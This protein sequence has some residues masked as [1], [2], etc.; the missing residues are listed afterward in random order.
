MGGGRN[1][2]SRPQIGPIERQGMSTIG[3]TFNGFRHARSDSNR[4]DTTRLALWVRTDYNAPA[5]KMAFAGDEASMAGHP[6]V[7]HMKL[8]LMLA[9]MFIVAAPTI[10]QAQQLEAIDKPTLQEAE[11]LVET[12][13]AD[14]EKLQAYCE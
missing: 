10:A 12:I 11:R 9:V 7:S 4:L 13:R 5:R 1:W 14:G 8:N 6:T 3:P 2:R